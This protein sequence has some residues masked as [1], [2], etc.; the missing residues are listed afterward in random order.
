MSAQPLATGEMCRE[1]RERLVQQRMEDMRRKNEELL[2]RHAE[3][4]ADKKNA[5]LLSRAAI[6]DCS[7]RKPPPAESSTSPRD[8]AE[9]KPPKP[10]EPRVR[11]VP[12]PVED[13]LTH[14]MQRL[15]MEDG[16][17]PDP[18]YRFLADRMREGDADGGGDRGGS[19]RHRD[20]YGGQDFDNVRHAMRQDKALQRESGP[21]LPPKLAMTGRQR[22]EYEQ[23]KSDRAAIDQERMQ[24]HTDAEGNFTREWDLHK[25]QKQMGLSSPL[26]D[27][28][29]P[30]GGF[31]LGSR[32]HM[33]EI[34][35]PPS[36]P[37]IW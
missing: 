31:S 5:D 3:I 16:P 34:P 8:N 14:R 29:A 13:S 1:E 7:L 30:L 27:C 25:G 21:V 28:R 4:E 33:R 11:P 2:R 19:R 35:S 18:N 6:K 17:P 9:K 22:R 15:S 26:T 24:R 37:E 36:E 20:N 32:T 23:W 12:P 10:R